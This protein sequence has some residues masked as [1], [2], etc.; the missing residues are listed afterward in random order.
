MVSEP[1]FS[2]E[3]LILNYVMRLNCVESFYVLLLHFRSK[4]SKR[5]AGQGQ[6]PSRG[7]QTRPGH[8]QGGG[9][10][11]PGPACKGRQT[12][13]AFGRLP[14]EATVHRGG[15]CG[16]KRRPQGLSPAAKRDSAY[17]GTAYGSK[18]DRRGTGPLAEQRPTVAIAPYKGATG[19][20]Q[21]PVHKG[22][23]AAGRCPKGWL[24][25]QGAARPRR[26]CGGSD[27]PWPNPS[28]GHGEAIGAA[29]AHGQP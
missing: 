26:G 21:G 4:G 7:G 5:V 2:C 23:S 17:G 3:R 20:G 27:R 1:R 22:R 25:P 19:Y 18:A 16:Q 6:A 28:A 9:W 15:D 29:P 11:R 24:K 10:L 8:R 12:P 14:A 13:A